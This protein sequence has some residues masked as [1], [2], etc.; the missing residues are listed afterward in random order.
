L[1]LELVVAGWVELEVAELLPGGGDSDVWVLDQ[2]EDGFRSTL[3][4]TWAEG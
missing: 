4:L 1:G 2:D 3:G